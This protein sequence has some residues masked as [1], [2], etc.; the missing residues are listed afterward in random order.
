MFRFA[1]LDSLGRRDHIALKV[2]KT[3]MIAPPLRTYATRTF[4]TLNR[5]RHLVT[6]SKTLFDQGEN[7]IASDFGM[8]R[9]KLEHL[10][11]WGISDSLAANQVS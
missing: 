7:R 11:G 3:E 2:S 8:E 5:E 4:S 6:L 1:M 10:P 9:G